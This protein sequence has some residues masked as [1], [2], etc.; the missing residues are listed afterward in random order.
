M[1]SMVRTKSSDAA[2]PNRL[3]LNC[4]HMK[5]TGG[6]ENMSSVVGAANLVSWFSTAARVAE[7]LWQCHFE[8]G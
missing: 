5:P 3:S 8:C 1:F 7:L 4:I 2:L 6:S